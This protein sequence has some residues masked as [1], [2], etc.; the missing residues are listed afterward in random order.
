MKALANRHVLLL[1]PSFFGYE[2]EIKKTLETLGATV[3]AFDERPENDFL[4]KALIRLNQRRFI[5]GKIQ[6]Y[7]RDILTKIAQQPIDTIFLINPEAIDKEKLLLL[8]KQF[9]QAQVLIYVWDA[10]ANKPNAKTLLPLADRCF[11]F[12]SRDAEQ[13]EGV[14]FLPLFYIKAYEEMAKREARRSYDISF[15]GTIHSDRYHIVKAIQEQALAQGRQVFSYFYCPNLMVFLYRKYVTREL[16]GVDGKMISY[17]SL[18]QQQVLSIISQS[19]AVID[20][21]HPKQQGL[22]MRAIEMLGAKRKLI[23]TNQVIKTYDFYHSDNILLIERD[24]PKVNFNFVDGDY[25][26]IDSVTYR[27]YT[28]QNW[29]SRIFDVA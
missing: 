12:D 8:K 11:S 3:Y 6:R 21:E 17:Q 22:T 29:V 2:I 7:Y 1:C 5:A 18:S 24:N 19:K 27:K 23:A 16:R 13:Y 9:P 25:R 4:T 15:I 20:I 14:R 28:L 26:P 10:I